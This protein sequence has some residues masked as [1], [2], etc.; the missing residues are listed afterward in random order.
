M[1]TCATSP[2]LQELYDKAASCAQRDQPT[3]TM[4]KEPIEAISKSDCGDGHRSAGLRSGSRSE[5]VDQRGLFASPTGVRS[6]WLRHDLET[7]PKRLKPW[8]KAAQEPSHVLTESQVRALKKPSKKSAREIETRTSTSELRIR[9][10]SARSR[11]S[12]ESI[13]RP[14]SIPTPRSPLPSCTTA[15]TLW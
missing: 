13:N 11:A 10:M 1:A 12:G 9:T 2:S 3:Q 15:R 4:C 14:S 6:V 8:S 7:F 5:S